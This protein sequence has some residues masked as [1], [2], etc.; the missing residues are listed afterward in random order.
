MKKGSEFC[1]MKPDFPKEAYLIV[2]HLFDLAKPTDNKKYFPLEA[3]TDSLTRP[4]PE[5]IS[6]DK[7]I[8]KQKDVSLD[9]MTIVFPLTFDSLFPLKREYW[10]N[11]GQQ[12]DHVQRTNAI[13]KA[14]TY[15]DY[16]KVLVTPWYKNDKW[17]FYAAIPFLIN[18]QV[19]TVELFMKN[20][21][22]PVD[23][24]AS[25]CAFYTIGK[26]VTFNWKTKKIFQDDKKQDN[27]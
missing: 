27:K 20:S 8:E 16:Y 6:T 5:L 18:A 19:R 12:Y 9:D 22:W 17:N 10:D 25:N 26:P 11:P 21:D 15:R 24:R 2:V 3:I 23:V 14:L 13:M 4:I 1:Y 7:F